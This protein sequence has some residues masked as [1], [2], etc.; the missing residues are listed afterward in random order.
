MFITNAINVR[1]P[2]VTLSCYVMYIA[3]LLTNDENNYSYIKMYG[4]Q[5][6]LTMQDTVISY[7]NVS[8][9]LYKNKSQMICFYKLH[10]HKRKY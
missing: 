7:R 2:N 8:L 1:T 3:C 10:Y 9:R 6:L 4:C 5:R